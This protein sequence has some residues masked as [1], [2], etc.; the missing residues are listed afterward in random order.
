[1]YKKIISNKSLQAG[2][3]YLIASIINKAI[4]FVT[5]P[6]FTRLLTVKE[7]GNVS[8]Y[9]SYVSIIYY[10]MGLSSEY[11]IRNAFAD[12][13]NDVP[14][15]IAS[16][17]SLS[18]I[19]SLIVSAIVLILNKFVFQMTS[20]WICGFCLIQAAMTFFVNAKTYEL[21][22]RKAY[23]KRAIFM[24]GPNI[25]SVAVALSVLPFMAHNRDIGRMMSYVFSYIIFGLYCIIVVLKNA[26]V[27]Q[28]GKYWAYIIKIAPPLIVHGLS[29]IALSQL[30]RIMITSMR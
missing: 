10:F 15:Y 2:S 27:K 5:I 1:M 16:M 24:S 22:M 28:L 4:A 25:L 7:Y 17:Y 26:D 29:V 21:M 14:Q 6:I 9:S 23:Y 19:S 3:I 12:Y 11:T 30:D 18:V 20:F 8:T 13:E